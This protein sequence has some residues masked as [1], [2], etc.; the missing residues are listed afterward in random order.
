VQLVRGA[1][2]DGAFEERLRAA[3]G[4]S[5]Q[6]GRVI[7]SSYEAFP[8]GMGLDYERK[9]AYYVPGEPSIVAV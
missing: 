7:V 6:A 3:L 1:Q 5:P 2:S 4:M 9:F 8:Y